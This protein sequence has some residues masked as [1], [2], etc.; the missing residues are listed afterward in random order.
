[1]EAQVTARDL[2]EALEELLSQVSLLPGNHKPESLRDAYI[3]ANNV[4][5][6]YH[7][8]PV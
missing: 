8:Q 5:E 1:M 7:S 2:A 3:K 6:E 4:L